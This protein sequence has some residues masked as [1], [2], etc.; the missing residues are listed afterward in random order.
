MDNLKSEDRI[1]DVGFGSGLIGRLLSQY[2]F[3]C[4]NGVDAYGGELTPCIKEPYRNIYISDI[5]DF[6]FTH[7]DLIIMGDVMEHLTLDESRILLNEFTNGKCD[8][9]LISVPYNLPQ[10]PSKKNPFD[11]HKQPDITR[12]YMEK[13]FPYLDLIFE[14]E[15]EDYQGIIGVYHW[16]K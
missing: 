13:N 7:Y 12:E 15:M 6:E 4:I 14:K 1:L 11:E 8:H 9:L 3:K 5:L 16:S 2:G 10:A